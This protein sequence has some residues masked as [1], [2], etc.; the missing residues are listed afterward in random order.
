METV[1]KIAYSAY[2]DR[3]SRELRRAKIYDVASVI[4]LVGVLTLIW[5]VTPVS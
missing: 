3:Q 4:I 5:F 1:M 2:R